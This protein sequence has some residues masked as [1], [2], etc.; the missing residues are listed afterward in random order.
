MASAHVT[1]GQK[2][3]YQPNGSGSGMTRMQTWYRPVPLGE[4]F[5][6]TDSVLDD[7]IPTRPDL[8]DDPE[9]GR[10]KARPRASN[11]LS[12]HNCVKTSSHN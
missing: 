5:G 1:E 8:L 11:T 3:R 7:L 9:A 6:D 10:A 12:Q 2:L 4:L